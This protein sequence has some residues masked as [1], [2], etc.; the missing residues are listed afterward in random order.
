MGYVKLAMGDVEQVNKSN[1]LSWRELD[2]PMPLF[3]SI[4]P[5]IFATGM[6]GYEFMYGS[7]I[8]LSFTRHSRE[9]ESI[10]AGPLANLSLYRSLGTSD[11]MLGLRTGLLRPLGLIDISVELNVGSAEA[12]AAAEATGA[13]LLVF[14]GDTTTVRFAETSAEY[15]LSKTF[16]AAGIIAS[17]PI[18]DPL[19]LKVAV[20]YKSGP[21]G[22]L[23]GTLISFGETSDI[24]T[25][26]EFDYSGFYISAGLA[27]EF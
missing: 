13:T 9:V 8:I 2:L 20:R 3:Q 26:T 27:L 21:I 4:R 17:M 10:Y 12:W 19:V 7:S 5:T 1:I 11:V 18:I 6:V 15:S 24:T 25:L 14:E 23:D 16:T 22:F